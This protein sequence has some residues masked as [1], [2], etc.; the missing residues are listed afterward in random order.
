[1]ITIIKLK[2]QYEGHAKHALLAAMGSYL[3]Y[4]KVVI[5]VDEDVD[6]YNLED[7]MWAYLTRGRADTRAMILNDI[8]GLLPGC[9]EGSLGAACIDAT[10]PLGRALNSPASPSLEKT[11]S[12]CANGSAESPVTS[13]K[14]DQGAEGPS[15]FCPPSAKLRGCYR[16]I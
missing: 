14:H 12:T 2:V 1:M 9:Q 4:N 7:V 15:S 11:I 8:P 6:I 16:H 3:D 10:M 13:V 5:A